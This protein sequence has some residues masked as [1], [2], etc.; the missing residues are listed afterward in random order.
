MLRREADENSKTIIATMYQAGNGI[1]DKFDKIL[2]LADGR[3]TY[4]GP[5]H[6]AR[7]YFEDLGFACPKGANIAD[8]LTSVTV[9]TERIVL[10]GMEGKVPNTAAEFETAY[11]QSAIYTK[12]I[13]GIV[14]PDKLG[15]EKDDMIMAVTNEKKKAHIPRP[16]SAYTVNLW[17]QVIA[18]TIR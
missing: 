11:R 2:V 3:V 15:E 1:Y 17:D 10:S 9:L 5:R 8:F 6:L 12:M 4:Y 16:Q 14:E 18:C 7:G 13:D